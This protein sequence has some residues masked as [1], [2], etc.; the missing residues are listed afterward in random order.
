VGLRVSALSIN[1]AP[2]CQGSRDFKDS[3]LENGSS[4]GHNLALTV[5]VVPNLLDSGTGASG[6]RHCPLTLPHPARVQDA[7]FRVQGA[8]CRVQGS[9]FRHQG[10]GF[11]LAL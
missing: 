6:C 5:L 2:S 1:P 9:G 8:G 10:A 11:G 7:V 3:F 4:Q